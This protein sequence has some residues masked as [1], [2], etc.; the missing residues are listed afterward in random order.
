L[1]SKISFLGV[2]QIFK[3]YL[4]LC[5]DAPNFLNAEYQESTSDGEYLIWRG[6]YQIGG[7]DAKKHPLEQIYKKYNG[8]Y[9]VYH[10]EFGYFP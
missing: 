6:N 2:R 1:Q 4:A 5:T 7:A 8:E 9:L 3:P 10:D